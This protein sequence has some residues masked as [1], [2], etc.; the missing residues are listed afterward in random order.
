MNG[1][2]AKRRAAA[3]AGTVAATDVASQPLDAG[4]R[5]WLVSGYFGARNLGDEALLAGLLI[6]LRARGARVVRVLSIDP[7]HTRA[8]HGVPARRRVVGL[9][10]ALLASDVLVSGG[11]GLLQDVTSG[12]SLGYYLGVIRAARLLRRR[13]VVYGQSLGPLSVGGQRRVQRALQG[14][15]L[16]LRDAPSL[17][18]ANRLG[19]SATPV[20]DAALAL[21]VP[22]V[23]QRDALVLVPRGGLPKATLALRALGEEAQARG[24]QV[25]V[26]ACQPALDLPEVA[27]LETR[28]P[29]LRRL[30]DEPPEAALAA[31]AGA[32]LVAS[33]RLHGLVLATVAGVPHV[34][35][36]YDPKV[37][38][39][40]QRSAAP[41][42]PVPSDVASARSLAA[43]LERVLS[44]PALDPAA[45]TRLLRAAHEGIDWLVRV[46]LHEGSWPNA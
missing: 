18:L 46:A 22:A 40:A 13:V 23:T 16:G 37:A 24:M 31:L 29:G 15:P 36:A 26:L 42:W 34:G 32:R 2:P 8:V 6:G 12:R 39:F 44:M 4:G 7:D 20:A 27:R 33:V 10:A 28:L 3:A 1:P 25:E 45:R 21:P 38:G 19:L 41:C 17:A 5:R 9:P 30:P 43:E 14:L 11:G 35:L